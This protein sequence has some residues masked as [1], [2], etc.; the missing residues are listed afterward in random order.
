[1]VRVD[2]CGFKAS[3]VLD[4]VK[5]QSRQLVLTSATEIERPQRR[6]SHKLMRLDGLLNDNR[7][8]GLRSGR[9]VAGEERVIGGA[10]VDRPDV[11]VG[12]GGGRVSGLG[13][14]GVSDC[15]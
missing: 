15:G 14:G 13:S 3:A 8:A 11:E 6:L 9:L 4:W 2:G 12:P 5:K 10:S 1:M 7:L